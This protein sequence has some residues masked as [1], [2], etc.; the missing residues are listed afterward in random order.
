MS[1]FDLVFGLLECR[2]WLDD[3]RDVL[4]RSVF[5]DKCLREKGFQHVSWT[6]G[7]ICESK[8]GRLITGFKQRVGVGPEAFPEQSPFGFLVVNESPS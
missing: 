4:G 2:W 7:L 1:Q 8:V 5:W 3:K 6:G